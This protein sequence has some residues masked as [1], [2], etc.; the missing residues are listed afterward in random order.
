MVTSNQDISFRYNIP[1]KNKFQMLESSVEIP[2]LPVSSLDMIQ[3]LVRPLA[4]GKYRTF[5]FVIFFDSGAPTNLAL[6]SIINILIM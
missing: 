2:T 1:V 6:K 4:L 3:G 5:H